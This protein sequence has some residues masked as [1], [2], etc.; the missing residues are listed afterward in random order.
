MDGLI[1][2]SADFKF[3]AACQ[4][5]NFPAMVLLLK[6]TEAHALPGIWLAFALWCGVRFV[7]NAS[8]VWGQYA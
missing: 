2:A 4:F 6:M 3:S 5:I 8:R 1:F 7:E